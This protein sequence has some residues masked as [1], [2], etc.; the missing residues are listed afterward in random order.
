VQQHNAWRN[1]LRE[2]AGEVGRE[3]VGP[4]PAGERAPHGPESQLAG[5]HAEQQHLQYH[6]HAT[7]ETIAPHVV[8]VT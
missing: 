3:Q 8:T 5:V 4:L 2:D 1:G 6:R 7:P